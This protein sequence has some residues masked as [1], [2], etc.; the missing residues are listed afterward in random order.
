MGWLIL[1]TA[2]LVLLLAVVGL[3]H[4]RAELRRMAA[5][6]G[7][8]ADA[9]ARGSHEAQL[10]YPHIDLSACIGCGS[11]VQACPEEG[12]LGLV[13][14]QAAVIHGARCVGHGLCAQECPTGAITITLR[15]LGARRDIPVLSDNLE[16]KGMPGLFLAGE[17]TGQALIRTA[18]AHGIAVAHEV[19]ARVAVRPVAMPRPARRVLQPVGAGAR[20][21]ATEPAA[22]AD[23]VLDLCIVGAGPS[24]LACSL[25]AKERGLR[26]LTLEQDQLGGT[27]AK[28]P[29]RKLVMTQPVDLPLHGRLARTSYE[30]EELMQIWREVACAHRLPIRT[31]EELVGLERGADGVFLLR[32]RT[33]RYRARHVCLGL[34]RRG[35]PH[36]LGVPGE[37]LPKVAYSLLDA[38]SYQGRR[39]LVVG[40]G[41]SAV[42]AALGLAEQPGNEVTISYRKRAFFRL[43]AR[44]EQRL[45]EAIAAGRLQVLYGSEVIDIAADRVGLR[46]EG[47]ADE[48]EL[49]ND[50]VFVFAGGTPPF[51]LLESAGVSFDPAQREAVAPLA[52]QGTGLLRALV[53]GLTLATLALAWALLF[54]SYYVLP[55]VQRPESTWHDVL[56]P[57]SPLGAAL[58][59]AAVVL[60]VSNLLYLLR[61]A[62]VGRRIAG[63]LNQWLSFHI[64]SGVLAML[65]ALL[66]GAMAPRH[67]PGGYAFYCLA[68]LVVTG[69]IGRYF[70]SYLPKAA[71]GRELAL[72]EIQGR[73]AALSGEWDAQGGEFAPRVRA[74]VEELVAR[75][76][77]QRA[78][79]ARLRAL[80]ADR[81]RL[82]RALGALARDGRAQGIPD[83]QLASILRLAR[84]AHGV[85]HA[86]S[87]YEDL[88]GLLASWRFF[89][90][91]VAL[92]MVLLVIVHVVAAVRYGNV[93]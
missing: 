51:A 1:G 30:K 69:A 73:L 45:Q 21:P 80:V 38:Q 10:Q 52:E 23:D 39:I 42:E 59:A 85:A 60:I 71:N 14:G 24:G 82:R 16:A 74:Q 66:H 64:V 29:R 84:R 78:F 22:R 77:W 37:D 34:G 48:Y 5:T 20:A 92:L 67:T 4:R 56:E 75:G 72:D 76:H 13:H 7:E 46:L 11:C 88:R 35:T 81:L 40:G 36:T 49:A 70:Y 43:K 63:T 9:K 26:F 87:H 58:G 68:F 86:A 93:F 32:T 57:G 41:D 53:V 17:V 12:V 47:D 79:F 54:S 27:V 19:A 33:Q 83:S 25:A 28:Y 3:R 44:N 55:G 62:R 18:I 2:V 61:R 91:W 31:G 8:R 89:H 15:D 50:D 65:L 90:R 6:V